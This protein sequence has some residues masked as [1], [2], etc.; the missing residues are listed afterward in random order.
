[1]RLFASDHNC[2]GFIP[3]TLPA[4]LTIGPLTDTVHKLQVL[5]RY[6][7]TLVAVGMLQGQAV[8]AKQSAMHDA[9]VRHFVQTSA[10]SA[11]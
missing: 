4:S 9:E 10:C 5:A 7:S 1:M 8:I 6:G 3:A 11:I 2:L